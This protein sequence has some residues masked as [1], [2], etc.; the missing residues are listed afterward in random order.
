MLQATKGAAGKGRHVLS[1]RQHTNSER[2]QRSGHRAITS[3][4]STFPE[5]IPEQH[6]RAFSW[7]A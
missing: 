6:R 7:A 3:V 1:P 2:E 4:L 5:S